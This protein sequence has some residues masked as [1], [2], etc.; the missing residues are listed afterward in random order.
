MFIALVFSHS[1]LGSLV[2]VLAKINQ[3]GWIVLTR[4]RWSRPA[5]VSFQAA[6]NTAAAS[7]TGPSTQT[8]FMAGPDGV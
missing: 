3:A 7:N 1:L 2:I 8:R 5:A 6:G 4:K